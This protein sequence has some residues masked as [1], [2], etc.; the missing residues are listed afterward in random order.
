MNEKMRL[1]AC[2]SQFIV[3]L[4]IWPGHDQSSYQ[5]SS[6]TRKP[7][8][9]MLEPYTE[10]EKRILLNVLHSRIV[11]LIL[12]VLYLHSLL[13]CHPRIPFLTLYTINTEEQQKQSK[14]KKHVFYPLPHKI[15][16]YVYES[17]S[18]SHESMYHKR[19]GISWLVLF[20]SHH[21]V[22]HGEHKRHSNPNNHRRMKDN[23]KWNILCNLIHLRKS[24]H[25]LSILFGFSK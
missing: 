17:L 12:S 18:K 19:C 24:S 4:M 7:T 6:F 16:G 15:R 10:N 20:L 23:R 2:P 21:F 9:G 1:N 3:S 14:K 11:S 5:I 22:I 13:I 25:F 8:T